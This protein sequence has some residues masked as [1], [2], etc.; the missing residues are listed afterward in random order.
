[1]ADKSEVNEL[2]ELAE[3]VSTYSGG[4]SALTETASSYVG[5]IEESAKTPS[6]L[7]A[8]SLARR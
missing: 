7:S 2:N 4:A 5:S 3:D 1:M 8:E 6:G